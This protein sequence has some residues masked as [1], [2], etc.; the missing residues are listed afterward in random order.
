MSN[1]ALLL[2]AR[3]PVPG[4]VK[5]RLAAHCGPERAAQVAAQLIR[6]TV[7]LAAAHWPGAIYLYG[8][9]D[10]GH[11]LFH[12]LAK[13]FPLRL[14]TQ[15]PGDLGSKMHA[16]LSEGIAHHGAAAVLGCD[17]PHCPPP[18]LVEAYEQL[19]RG[20]NILGPAEDGGYYLLGLTAPC[21]ALFQGIVFGSD[22]VRRY[23][24]ARAAQAGVSFEL[25]PALRDIDTWDDLLGAAPRLPALAPFL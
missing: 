24:L 5:T 17:V 14:A 19:V 1:P 20:R 16:A 10:A 7:Q 4:E 11:P 8:A 12:E 22:T 21:A 9:P 2:F 15:T 23:T 6:A 18:V 13:E 25:L 3:Q